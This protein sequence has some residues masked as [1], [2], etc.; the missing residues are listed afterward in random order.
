MKLDRVVGADLSAPTDIIA[1]D[2]LIGQPFMN[3]RLKHGQGFL[4][5][6]LSRDVQCRFLRSRFVFE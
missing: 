5:Y 6:L 4:R 1:A 2:I 3:D